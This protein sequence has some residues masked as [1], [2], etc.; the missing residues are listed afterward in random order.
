MV[1][2]AN[3]LVTA[4]PQQA[5]LPTVSGYTNSSGQVTLPLVATSK[6]N[7]QFSGPAIGKVSDFVP[8]N[9]TFT[10]YTVKNKGTKSLSL[11]GNKL[12]GGKS[13]YAFKGSFLVKA[14][15]TFGSWQPSGL[16][17]NYKAKSTSLI[18]PSSNISINYV[19]TALTSFLTFD[20]YNGAYL[21]NTD[22]YDP[23]TNTWSAK[24]SDTTARFGIMAGRV[25]SFVYVVGG[26]DGTVLAVNHRY[27]IATNSWVDETPDL[28]A[29]Y[30]VAGGV[31]ASILYATFGYDTHV[32]KTNNAYDPSTNTWSAKANYNLTAG[33]YY[34]PAAWPAQSRLWIM[35]GD[36]YVSTSFKF[37]GYSNYSYNPSTNLWK[38]WPIWENPGGSYPALGAV[39]S[40]L[41][42]YGG[43][44]AAGPVDYVSKFK[45]EGSFVSYGLSP[46]PQGTQGMY[47]VAMASRLYAA[48]GYN[49]TSFLDTTN[50]YDTATN[51]WTAGATALHTGYAGAAAVV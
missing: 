28:S 19:S 26:Y 12:T 50:Y 20:G 30:G 34:A 11:S 2:I 5:G 6:Y 47:Y 25:G 8:A 18:M 3:A 9:T 43:R 42:H 10:L 16:F 29:T 32:L 35:G 13:L 37:Y 44:L 45:I 4:T 7:L 41:Y 23:S 14:L 17:K 49:G 51:T 31:I 21:A 36:V 24:A 40:Y 27:G 48:C 46:M 1:G 33:A 38:E 15:Q 22:K 39:G